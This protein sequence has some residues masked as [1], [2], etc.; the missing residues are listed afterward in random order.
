MREHLTPDCL[1]DQPSVFFA[2]G[3]Q[4]PDPR[5]D[6]LISVIVFPLMLTI[7]IAEFLFDVI[8]D[9]F[10]FVFDPVPNLPSTMDG[11]KVFQ[12]QA[13]VQ[14]FTLKSSGCHCC[15]LVV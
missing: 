8:T 14:S 1:I 12:T 10:S 15:E 5:L 3:G 2:D 6:R 11:G 13:F 9:V 4:D 7:A